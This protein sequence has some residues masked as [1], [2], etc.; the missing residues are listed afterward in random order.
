METKKTSKRLHVEDYKVGWVTALK[1]ELAAAIAVLDEEHEKP[2]D[3]EAPSS[4]SN[5]YTL[6]RIGEHNIV[7]T[8]IAAGTY[9]IVSATATALPMLSTFPQ[10]RF[11]LL[12]GIGAGIA[13]P[14][15]NRD[16]RLGDIVVSQPSGTSGGVIQYDSLK[17]ISGGAR[18]RRGHLNQPPDILLKALKKL[19][20]YHDL[21]D[22]LVPHF[23]QQA[24]D[25]RPRLKKLK[26]GY[27]HQGHRHDRL[28]K[29]TYKHVPTIDCGKCDPNEEVEREERDSTDPE[30]HYGAIASGNTLIKDAVH[31]DAIAAEMDDQ[32]ICFE[33]E[34][35][36][37]MND[38]PCLVIRG[39]A[40]YADSHKNDRWH[41]YA[42]LTAA[43]YAKELLG[44]IPSDDIQRSRKAI[45]VMESIAEDTSVLRSRTLNIESTVNMLNGNERQ[46][47]IN[48][49]LSPPDYS[50]NLNE[51]LRKRHPG[52][53][54]W[55]IESELFHDWKMTR[56]PRVLWLYGIPGAGKTVLSSTIIEDL[57]RHTTT[58]DNK[59]SYPAVLQF[60]FDSNNRDKQSLDSLVR[61]LVSQLYTQVERSAEFLES[62]FS[63]CAHRQPA[64]ET[65]LTTLE[66]MMHNAPDVYLVID[67]LS[68]CETRKGLL[69]WLKSLA[70]PEYMNVHLLFT[71]RNEGAIEAHIAEWLTEE[72]KVY[73]KKDLVNIDIQ[74]YIRGVLL[75]SNGEFR[76]WSSAPTILE[77]IETKLMEKAN[78]MFQWAAC[79]IDILQECLNLPQLRKALSSLPRTLE[80]TYSRILKSIKEEFRDDA[81]RLLQFLTHSKRPLTLD[82]AV[83]AIAVDPNCNPPFDPM[84]RLPNP[85]EITRV[86]SSLVSVVER[87]FMHE[88]ESIFEVQLAHTSV[89]EYLKSTRIEEEF[90]HGLDDATC[91]GEIVRVCLAYLTYVTGRGSIIDIL[92]SFPLVRYASHHW[93][94]HAASGENR[95][96]VLESIMNFLDR[97]GE[98]YIFWS[99][100]QDFN[101]PWK[102]KPSEWLKE[103]DVLSPLYWASSAGLQQS[104]K[105]LL[106]CGNSPNVSGGRYGNPLQA[107]CHGGHER[108]VRALLH[109]GADINAKGGTYGTPLQAACFRG[110]DDLVR[111]LIHCGADVHADGGRYGTVL[112]AACAGGHETVV[113]II[114]EENVDVN[115]MHPHLGTALQSACK[116]GKLSS[117]LTLLDRGADINLQCGILHTALQAASSIGNS[118]LVEALLER[119]A[120]I[121]AAGGL[122]NCALGAAC[123][124]GHVAVIRLLLDQGAQYLVHIFKSPLESACENGSVAAVQVLLDHFP[125]SELNI[126]TGIA[127]AS[128]RGHT[129]VVLALLNAEV[130]ISAR[131]DLARSALDSACLFGHAKLV[132][133]L[134]DMHADSTSQLGWQCDGKILQITC[135]RGHAEMIETLF[136]LNVLDNNDCGKALQAA[137]ESGKETVIQVILNHTKAFLWPSVHGQALR[138]AAYGGHE[139]IVANFLSSDINANPPPAS[140]VNSS[141]RVA[142]FTGREDIVKMLLDYAADVNSQ[143][144]FL[145]NALQAASYHGNG[146]LVRQLLQ[147][148]ANVNS[149]A[150]HYGTALQAASYRGHLWIVQTLLNHEADANF[151]GGYYGS[152]L[153]AASYKGHVQVVQVL[154]DHGADVNLQGGILGT[155]LQAATVMGHVRVAQ[156]LLQNNANPDLQLDSEID[157]L[158]QTYDKYHDHV[159]KILMSQAPNE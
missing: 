50:T 89:R 119:G 12:V 148:G 54:L 35:A 53:G 68:E 159:V 81:I 153:H 76:R 72:D 135:S 99:Y 30:I 109:H 57:L 128:R 70:G 105:L 113:K 155:A 131:H 146:R 19:Q 144:D 134:L 55:F 149:H 31:R 107:A 67:S 4:D 79:Q 40:D 78:G 24:I 143:G 132:Q 139:R 21:S 118:R 133:T 59:D 28:F 13:R 1:E 32:V 87:K 145:G 45:D 3:F 142:A 136:S 147:A 62:L 60:F 111:L 82:E 8:T 39:I 154:L 106:D 141:L 127:T 130:D 61:S 102:H 112:H 5:S 124:E 63:K 66:A 15:Q 92:E 125:H 71:S 115:A 116:K 122:Y 17:V 83:D 56:N 42:A 80:E 47:K 108:V 77:E 158:L 16:I 140:F 101:E 104:V 151:R 6:G 20:A 34:A 98:A 110:F 46:K 96:D 10:I 138:G 29:A 73:L 65:L 93:L 86:C 88:S 36:G 150:G 114:L 157:V 129:N 74:T 49:W 94:H 27:I 103:M 137:C 11:G 23:L 41:R 25:R 33:T 22:S 126:S 43:A 58:G 37:L 152:S 48:D 51:A 2:V 95:P 9:G 117:A 121:N 18:E 69:E 85:R 38:F 97:H 123:S 84:M 91:Q 100:L 156:L 26:P 120:N 14:E 52:T 64:T 75:H 7:I 90:Q 44:H